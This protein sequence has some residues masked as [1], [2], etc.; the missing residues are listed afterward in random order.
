M[1]KAFEQ[2]L[3]WV[4]IRCSFNL[5]LEQT[6]RVFAAA[7]VI[8]ILTVLA[9]RL[10][11]LSVINSFTLWSFTALA[12]ALA[13]LFWLLNQPSRMQMALLLDQRLKLH[14]RFSTTLAMAESKDPFARAYMSVSVL[15]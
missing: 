8:G 11:A 10:L 12:I 13:L 7:G 15:H 2:K 5:L 9:E 4:R 3:R 1:L 14:E 6:G